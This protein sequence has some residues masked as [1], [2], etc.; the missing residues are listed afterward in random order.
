M[1]RNRSEKIPRPDLSAEMHRYIRLRA[2]TVRVIT[3]DYGVKLSDIRARRRAAYHE[4]SSD[5]KNLWAR[6]GYEPRERKV[7]YDYYEQQ[8]RVGHTFRKD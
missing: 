3:E 7:L 2:I 8:F 5:E 4:L 6:M 1:P